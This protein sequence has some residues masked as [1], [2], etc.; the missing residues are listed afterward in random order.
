MLG[1]LM[2]NIPSIVMIVLLVIAWRKEIVGAVSYF[3]AGLLYIGLVTFRAINSDLPWYLAITWSLTIAGP[4]F[5][6]GVLFLFNWKKRNEMRT[7]HK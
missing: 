1:L 7:N 4:A 5:I 6:A 3:G 2:H